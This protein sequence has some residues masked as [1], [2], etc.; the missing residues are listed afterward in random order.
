MHS[1]GWRMFVA[2][3]IAVATTTVPLL[4]LLLVQFHLM[5]YRLVCNYPII[6]RNHSNQ[7]TYTMRCYTYLTC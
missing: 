6:V 4:L 5:Q 1:F 3:A 2:I 7:I